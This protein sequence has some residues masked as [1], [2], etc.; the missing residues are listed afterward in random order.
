MKRLTFLLLLLLFLLPTGFARSKSNDLGQW[1][2][3]SLELPVSDKVKA[4]LDL[5][6]RLN[7]NITSKD[8][9]FI[10]PSIGYQVTPH[11]SLWQGY[12]W[13]PKFN[14]G[15]RNENRV[16][17]QVLF[18]HSYKDI[19]ITNRI[20]LEERFIANVPG[21]SV[22][23]RH[24]FRLSKP[25]G[26]HKKWYLLTSN[27]FFVNINSK[28]GGPQSGFDQNRSFIGL[29]RKLTRHVSVEAGYQLQ[30][31]NERDTPDNLNHIGLVNLKVKL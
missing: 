26:H 30:Y 20:R 8:Q 17:Q 14:D 18:E 9:L 21:T 12:T 16:W 29:G 24:L 11:V 15:M 27:E 5:Q 4:S 25:F 13:A 22:R 2:A 19:A 10:R 1:D 23:G 31:V 28:M 7:Q 6:G 3:I